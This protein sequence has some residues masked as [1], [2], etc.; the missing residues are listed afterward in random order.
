MEDNMLTIQ[1][2]NDEQTVLSFFK[3]EWDD[4]KH[5]VHCQCVIDA[6]LGMIAGTTYDPLIFCFAGWLHDMGKIIDKKTHHEKSLI[7]ADKFF[8][9]H[10]EYE[11]YRNIVG[12]CILHHRTGGTPQSDEARIFQLADKVAL[13]NKKWLDYKDSVK[14]NK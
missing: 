6:C 9:Q 3:V 4:N 13:Q 11:H 2:Q 1:Q 10:P 5:L 14:P 8:K 12:E 7:Y